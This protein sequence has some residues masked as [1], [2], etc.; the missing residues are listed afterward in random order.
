MFRQPLINQDQIKTEIDKDQSKEQ[1]TEL[2]FRERANKF[3]GKIH[4]LL[5]IKTEY[6]QITDEEKIT[7]ITH[8]E[9]VLELI[10]K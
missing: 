2:S 9:E 10:K 7:R 1:K 3:E 5:F 4:T 6:K 8:K